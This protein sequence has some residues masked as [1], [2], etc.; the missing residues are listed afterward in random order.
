MGICLVMSKVLIVGGSGFIGQNVIK[1][2]LALNWDVYSLNLQFHNLNSK[3]KNIVE[4]VCDVRN[5]EDLKNA[6]SKYEFIYVI[7]CLGY[8]DHSNLNSGGLN[9][10]HTHFIGT[11]NLISVLNKGCLRKFINIGS[12][13][14]YGYSIA[15]QVETMNESPFSCYSFS[16]TCISNFLKMMYVSESFPSIILR[17]FLTYG[18]D[19]NDDRFLPQ[20]INGCLSDS[21]FPVSEGNQIRD[22]CFI[23]DIVDAIIISLESDVNNAEIFNIASGEPIKI[24]N[25]VLLIKEITSKGNPI[26]GAIPYRNNEVMELYANIDKAKHILKWFP[27][28]NLYDG[29]TLTIKAKNKNI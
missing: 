25:I 8:V 6:L 16:K 4:I 23:S 12:S 7:N 27:K 14:E 11:V 9:V 19:Q 24:K 26:F 28:V 3:Y 2:C 13:D 21:E 18:P 29:L 20:I 15:P 22:F 17:I 10:I 5:L 1:R